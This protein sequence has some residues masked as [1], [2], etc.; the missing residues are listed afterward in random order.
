M[1]I[2]DEA[3]RRYEQD[4][5]MWASRSREGREPARPE[6][7]GLRPVP[8]API[9]CSR[10]TF[11]IRRE[12]AELDDLAARLLAESEGLRS[13]SDVTSPRV[14]GTKGGK[15]PSPLAD[16][17]DELESELRSWEE[18]FRGKPASAR[19]GYLTSVLTAEVD[20]LGAHFDQCIA[21]PQYA[22]DFGQA[23]RNWHRKMRNAGHAGIVR[24]KMKKP[25]PRCDA[26]SL[27]WEEGADYVQCQRTECSRMM[28]YQEYKDWED[29]H[30]HLAGSS[31]AI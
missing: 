10:C 12:L 3:M 9:W 26:F 21:H 8:G 5:E 14:S 6:K 2:F 4:Y 31:A 11:T 24:H 17:V 18:D 28:S 30:P 27:V 7:P 29:L 1:A 23:V 13:T 16:L 20:W 25:C 15:S 22:Q 19:R